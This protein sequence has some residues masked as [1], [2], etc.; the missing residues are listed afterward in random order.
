M[1]KVVINNDSF[2]VGNGRE[3]S[4]LFRKAVKAGYYS[5][6][7]EGP[8]Y[9]EGRTYCLWFDSEGPAWTPGTVN[10]DNFVK[11]VQEVM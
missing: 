2:Y 11:Y 10:F 3:I 4:R 9:A 7:T 8:A 1:R 6:Y 5:L